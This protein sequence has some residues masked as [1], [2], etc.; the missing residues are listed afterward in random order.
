MTNEE[1]G[2]GKGLFIGIMTGAAVGS[3]IALLYAPKSGKKFREEIKTRSQDL[4]EDADKYIIKARKKALQIIKDIKKKSGF[5]VSDAEEKVDALMDETEK[6]LGETK[7]RIVKYAVTGR[8][9]LEKESGR[10][11]SAVKE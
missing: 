9:K 10:I 4:I 1:K 11:K 3:V 8:A 5:W 2:I 6:T 7:E